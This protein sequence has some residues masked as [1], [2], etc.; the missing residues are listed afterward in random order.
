MKNLSSTLFVTLRR[1]ITQQLLDSAFKLLAYSPSQECS[2]SF[3]EF[4]PHTANSC[5][6][7]NQ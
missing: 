5:C 7:C 4:A 1:A 2:V 3:T 6:Q